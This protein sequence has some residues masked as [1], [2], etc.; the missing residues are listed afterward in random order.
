MSEAERD[1]SIERILVAL[2]ASSH[3]VAALETAAELA[4]VFDAKLIGLFVEDVNLVRAAELPFSQEIGFFSPV[5]RQMQ[6]SELERLF[7]VQAGMMRE[8]MQQIAG[9]R[10]LA[11]E[12]KVARGPVSAELL[13]AE[14]DA[15]LT[16]LGRIGRAP[17]TPRR[18]GSTVRMVVMQGRRLTMILHQD[19]WL[20]ATPVMAIFDGSPVA[21][22]ALQAARKLARTR[23]GGLLL[24][25]VAE[26]PETA[27]RLHDKLSGRPAGDLQVRHRVLVAPGIEKIARF[28]RMEGDGPVV[29]PCGDGIF[30]GEKL[31][32]LVDMVP[33]PVLLVR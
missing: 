12:F 18:M 11:W 2:D 17:G 14:A 15:D 26:D 32:A 9:R 19:S 7:R 5:L 6:L 3:S 31:C 27:R 25:I 24:F 20:I 30:Y 23:D 22:K 1:L 4:S 21:E 16:V 28:V 10:Q 13:S 29:V 33:N 8:T